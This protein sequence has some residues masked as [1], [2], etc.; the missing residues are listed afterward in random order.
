MAISLEQLCCKSLFLFITWLL[1]RIRDNVVGI[2]TRI[3]AEQRGRLG[4][5]PVRG[6]GF[7]FS[8]ILDRVWGPSNLLFGR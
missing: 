6:K 5:I 8:K 4:W 2:V 7:F 3:R 1:S